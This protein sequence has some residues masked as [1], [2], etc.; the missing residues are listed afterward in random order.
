MKRLALPVEG[1]AGTE[2][3]SSPRVTA[4]ATKRSS[5]STRRSTLQA[6]PVERR[7]WAAPLHRLGVGEISTHRFLLE[8]GLEGRTS[9]SPPVPRAL[10]LGT[11]PP[12]GWG[13]GVPRS[14]LIRR[15]PGRS[16]TNMIPPGK[17]GQPQGCSSPGHHR[18]PFSHGTPPS[19]WTVVPPMG[20]LPAAVSALGPPQAANAAVSPPTRIHRLHIS[21]PVASGWAPWREVERDPSG[22]EPAGD[23]LPAGEDP[24]SGKGLVGCAS[25]AFLRWGSAL[26]GTTVPECRV[27]RLEDRLRGVGAGDGVAIP[28]HEEGTP[29]S[30]VAPPHTVPSSNPARPPSPSSTRRSRRPIEPAPGRSR[31]EVLPVVQVHFRR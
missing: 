9:R 25:A 8:V 13:G 30:P 7:G 15:R 6:P 11:P 19:T 2:V 21:P 1:Q 12:P 22:T 26:R 5:P 17:Q 10:Q 29:G 24:G 14:G 31:E 4:S 27:H 20:G 18:P 3:L 23:A 28:E 16:V